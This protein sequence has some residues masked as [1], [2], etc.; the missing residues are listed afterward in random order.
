MYWVKSGGFTL[1][2]LSLIFTFGNISSSSLTIPTNWATLSS[3]QLSF[4]G[5]PYSCA[6]S[7]AISLPK[8]SQCLPAPAPIKGAHLLLL[9]C[10]IR[11]VQSGSVILNRRCVRT[12]DSSIKIF[13]ISDQDTLAIELAHLH[14]SNS[15]SLYT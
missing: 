12:Y 9:I 7:Y 1:V 3:C 10:L 6:Q 5:Y 2:N 11:F 4:K 8:G 15:F 13:E 14:T